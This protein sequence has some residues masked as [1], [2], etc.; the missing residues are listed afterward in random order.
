M[1]E[2]YMESKISDFEQRTPDTIRE[3]ERKSRQA[4]TINQLTYHIETQLNEFKRK[5]Q[6][7]VCQIIASIE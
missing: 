5:L 7:E 1:R 6:G 3:L 4:N 2:H